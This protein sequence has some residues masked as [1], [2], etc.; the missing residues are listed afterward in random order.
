MLWN[1]TKNN[2]AMITSDDIWTF[3][4]FLSFFLKIWGPLKN[5]FLAIFL[6]K[7]WK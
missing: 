2:L 4:G 7:F 6:D 1:L 3:L 5:K